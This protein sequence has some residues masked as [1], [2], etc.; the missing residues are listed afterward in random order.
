MAGVIALAGLM[1]A[2]VE[3]DRDRR[4]REQLVLQAQ[5]IAQHL[6][7]AT[8]P[9]A[10]A[11]SIQDALRHALPAATGRMVL[12]VYDTTGG[13]RAA[14][15]R[16]EPAPA[17]RAD[18]RR[19]AWMTDVQVVTASGKTWELRLTQPVSDLVDLA[20]GYHAYLL[21]GLII[22]AVLS[23]ALWYLQRRS[24]G[25]RA[26]QDFELLQSVVDS[27][28]APVFVKDA[29]HRYIVL[30]RAF[31]KAFGIPAHDLI[32]KTDEPLNDP[33]TAQARSAEDGRAFSPDTITVSTQ[34]DIDAQG[35]QRHWIKSKAALQ[36][37]AGERG[38][39][40]IL[41]EVTAQHEAEARA[42]SS[43][44]FMQAALDALPLPMYIK[45]DRFEWIL[46]NDAFTHLMGRQAR[47]LIGRS[48]ADFWGEETVRRYRQ[49]DHEALLSVDSVARE[50]EVALPGGRVV[51]LVTHRRSLNAGHQRHLIGV[52]IDVTSLRASSKELEHAHQFLRAIVD[53][54][55]HSLVVKDESGYYLIVN[56]A[57]CDAVAI[58][59]EQV[60]GRTAREIFSE[61]I[62]AKLEAQDA[63]SWATGNIITAIQPRINLRGAAGW[64]LKSKRVVQ[65]PNG[66][67]YNVQ[68]TT[69]VTAHQQ[70]LQ[71]AQRSKELLRGILDAIPNPLI[72]KDANR[73]YALIN[74]A[75]I[76][77]G[78]PGR[79]RIGAC[80]ADVFPQEVSVRYAQEDELALAESQT[81]WYAD[82]RV[83]AD[84]SERWWLKSKRGITLW[85][86]ERMIVAVLSDVTALKLAERD[87]MR[88]QSRLQLLHDLSLLM[89][90][91]PDLYTL[92]QGACEA[93][94]RRLERR[95]V[96][97]GTTDTDRKAP[98][99]AHADDFPSSSWPSFTLDLQAIPAMLPKQCHLGMF[100][101]SDQ[102]MPSDLVTWRCIC[103]DHDRVTTIVVPLSL[104]GRVIGLFAFEGLVTQPWEPHER[105]LIV[106]A[107]DMLRIASRAQQAEASRQAAEAA[108]RRSEA[109]LRAH[110]DNLQAL[111]E[112]RTVELK[113]TMQLAEAATRS[114]SQF[115]NNMSHELRT[116][117][118]S[119]LSFARLGL[120]MARNGQLDSSTSHTY[121]ERIERGANRL[122]LLIN[123]LLDLAKLES[124]RM[125]YRFAQ[126]DVRALI[127]S[128]CEELAALASKDNV[129]FQ[130]ECLV[131]PATAFCDEVRMEQVIRNLLANA[132]RFSPPQACVVIR[133]NSTIHAT[134][135][136]DGTCQV[137]DALEITVVDQGPGIPPE[138]LDLIFDKYVQS[139]RVR[140]QGTGLGLPIARE[141]VTH[142]GGT[143][144]ASNAA[145]GG[146]VM[147]ITLPT[148]PSAAKSPTVD[149]PAT[150]EPAT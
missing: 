137:V 31:V 10:S 136:P 11:Y 102:S 64:S 149:S 7:A 17:S 144:L 30:N 83:N 141:I 94:A 104:G 44:T 130:I 121:L 62:A 27:L 42:R 4:A 72:V 65:L 60:L 71:E 113:H 99:I 122:L 53:A 43:Q 67:R 40:G 46:V 147:T 37:A 109:E 34:S 82:H 47:D 97:F 92:G 123:D 69:D 48:D 132:L 86:D 16:Y 112:E 28:P 56:R 66:H 110:R 126:R 33:A 50:E 134:E 135:T 13:A 32:G 15:Y 85:N 142:H 75:A 54:L 96:S 49:H 105:Q 76:S 150:S 70:A 9:Q 6:A 36:L 5:R 108:L 58:D 95:R 100:E 91:Q 124:G 51:H 12:E 87:L 103:P 77:L 3:G 116:P 2:S 22:I 73:N 45:N 20:G 74:S 140:G 81:R 79:M 106:E 18:S 129:T 107:A 114:K 61:E 145:H 78:P 148:A 1:Y 131:E 68:V 111:V 19:E 63:E 52:I 98:V 8:T 59:S 80:D 39:C 84:G 55:P 38:V 146:A 41:M 133:I 29:D 128:V 125:A 101:F 138:E 25:W 127:D 115:F 143:L 118:N 119:I 14:I 24:F 139:S 120:E 90:Q 93:L 21:T 35:R 26:R 117:M 88:N 89:L 23:I 57:W